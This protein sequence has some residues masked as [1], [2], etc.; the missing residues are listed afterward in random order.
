MPNR[1]PA[2]QHNKFLTLQYMET[3]R[4]IEIFPLRRRTPVWQ[5]VLVRTNEK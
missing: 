4:T 3:L 2:C 1:Q 5:P